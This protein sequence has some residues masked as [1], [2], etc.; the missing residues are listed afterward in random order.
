[1]R[2]LHCS[3]NSAGDTMTRRRFLELVGQAGG[4]SAVYGAMSA[5]GLMA[6]P[7]TTGRAG[8]KF[9]LRGNGNG[10][11][12]LILRAGLAGLCA[13]YELQKIGYDCQIL[14]AR[15]R[16]GGR[17]TRSVAARPKSN[18][19]AERRRATFDDGEYFNCGATRIPQQH[20]TLDYCRELGVAVE[21]WGNLNESA[22][23]YREHGGAL[24]GKRIRLH[25]AARTCTGT[26]RSCSREG[27]R[28]EGSGCATDRRR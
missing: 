25:E 3:F 1:M 22:Y 21:Q 17:R 18:R 15:T 16:V 5:M 8:S 7:P 2:T 26:S 23:L 12:V 6:Q 14:E 4:A 10:R 11:R 20:C 24:S 27:D 28:S 9:E 19:T 13:A